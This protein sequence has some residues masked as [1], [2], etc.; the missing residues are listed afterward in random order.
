MISAVK[1]SLQEVFRYVGI[2]RLDKVL[3]MFSYD[4]IWNVERKRF[5]D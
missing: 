3:R 1:N 5:V 4:G 2:D